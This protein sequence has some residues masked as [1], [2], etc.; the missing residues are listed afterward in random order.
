M[1]NLLILLTLTNIHDSSSEANDDTDDDINDRENNFNTS[2][3]EVIYKSNS[4]DTSTD[5]DNDTEDNS[6]C[7][8][9]L[10]S[11]AEDSVNYRKGIDY[12]RIEPN[13][14][15]SDAV[16]EINVIH[17]K[18]F[19]FCK[20][21]DVPFIDSSEIIEVMA[22]IRRRKCDD[23]ILI[24]TKSNSCRL[25]KV[26][27]VIGGI[28]YF[29]E[30]NKPYAGYE[31]LPNQIRMVHSNKEVAAE[32]YDLSTVIIKDEDPLIFM[33]YVYKI[34]QAHFNILGLMINQ[35]ISDNV[36]KTQ[37]IERFVFVE[38]IKAILNSDPN[39]KYSEIDSYKSI[40]Y[41]P[42]CVILFALLINKW[43][44]DSENYD[45][46][47]ARAIF[48]IC[49]SNSGEKKMKKDANHAFDLI[50]N[51]NIVNY[52]SDIISQLFAINIRPTGSRALIDQLVEVKKK[53]EDSSESDEDETEQT[54]IEQQDST[55]GDSGDD[56]ETG[57]SDDSN[58]SGDSDDSKKSSD[59]DEGVDL[60]SNYMIDEAWFFNKLIKALVRFLENHDVDNL[61][62]ET[63][64]DNRKLVKDKDGKG[65]YLYDD[66]VDSF[67][68]IVIKKKDIRFVVNNKS[69]FDKSNIR[70]VY[71]PIKKDGKLD[72]KT[73][74]ELKQ[75]N[76]LTLSSLNTLN[77]C[78]ILE[79]SSGIGK[80]YFVK[81]TSLTEY[82]NVLLIKKLDPKCIG[83]H[84]VVPNI[85]SY[86]ETNGTFSIGCEY[87][88]LSLGQIFLYNKRGD[89]SLPLRQLTTC[90][91]R[92]K[93]H[94]LIFG[95]IKTNNAM[96]DVNFDEDNEPI[97]NLVMIDWESLGIR[98]KLATKQD[99]DFKYLAPC[100]YM[101][102]AY[103]NHNHHD[104]FVSE[105][106]ADMYQL[107]M[108]IIDCLIYLKHVTHIDTLNS[109]HNFLV[110]FSRQLFIGEAAM[111][112]YLSMH[113]RCKITDLT[114]NKLVTL[115][116]KLHNSC[117]DLKYKATIRNIQK[118]YD[119]IKSDKIVMDDINKKSG[120]T[121]V[122]KVKNI[123]KYTNNSLVEKESFHTPKDMVNY[124]GLFK[125]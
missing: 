70:Y 32:T 81:D 114:L 112:S 92:L 44:H 64:I 91:F 21:K 96:L 99:K 76:S 16:N 5:D 4:S 74:V 33:N 19:M 14:G 28:M 107:F 39:I 124:M 100:S 88:E 115:I 1:R 35:S 71:H 47:K 18:V 54:E 6:E 9:Y 103:T 94:S 27:N 46:K 120:R 7:D 123:F 116:Y 24:K 65:D 60:K 53:S 25:T 113:Y 68:D 17:P 48:D 122:Y 8:H 118:M 12:L 37:N 22:E 78:D 102:Y 11:Y 50:S 15:S 62:C 26:S 52:I 13:V 79:Q 95:D 3:E 109:R 82:L 10:W 73:E 90:V 110:E 93:E 72:L 101:S 45:K 108:V 69:L 2:D 49:C 106:K 38:L 31:N 29:Q 77:K 98:P 20:K 63:I 121:S 41:V 117:M 119:L 66:F 43:K 67:K 125:Q 83:R 86:D 105:D 57:E 104:Y 30:N 56:S 42:C 111:L 58:S 51:M 40:R 34:T 36:S 87:R 61:S 23:S 85:W 97:Y 59:S 89:L 84:V 75:C 80:K 55:D